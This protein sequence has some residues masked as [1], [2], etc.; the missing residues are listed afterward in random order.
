MGKPLFKSVLM[1]LSMAVVLPSALL[2]AFG[3]NLVVYQFFAHLHALIPGLPGDY[4]RAA[5]YRWTLEGFGNDSRIQF[6][7]Y[8]AHPEARVGRG[9][10]IGVMNIFGRTTIGDE[11]Q[12]ASAVQI[13]SGNRQHRRREDGSLS[14]SE[15]G[16]FEMVSI[17]KGCWIGAGAI[18]MADIGENTTVGAGSVVTKALPPN[19]TAVGSP[20]RVVEPGS[21]GSQPSA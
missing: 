10:Y 12:I 21:R 16:A 13:L 6:G 4:L 11:C 8:F 9:V 15:D 7:S 18:V 17:G 14:G 5:Y 19:C 1:A 2:S 20:A 3:R